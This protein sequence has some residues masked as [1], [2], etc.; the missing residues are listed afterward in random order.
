MGLEPTRPKTLEPKSSAS[1]IPPLARSKKSSSHAEVMMTDFRELD[2]S[3]VLVGLSR[4]DSQIAAQAGDM[5][6]G[7]DVVERV[8][9]DAFTIDGKR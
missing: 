7:L 8:G 5:S 3:P 4:V 2:F 6:G 9:D 1:T